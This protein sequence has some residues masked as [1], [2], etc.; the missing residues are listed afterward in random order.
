MTEPVLKRYQL[1]SGGVRI[2]GAISTAGAI[3]VCGTFAPQQGT[4]GDGRRSGFAING[5][6]R[7]AFQS[8]ADWDLESPGFVFCATDALA[9]NP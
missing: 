1:P 3:R 6:S 8:H 9:R 4:D 7:G 2:L 5:F